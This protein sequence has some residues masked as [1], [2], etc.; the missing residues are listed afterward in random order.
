MVLVVALANDSPTAQLLASTC[1]SGTWQMALDGALLQ[2]RQAALR[3]Y[4]WQR[5]TLS[6]GFHQPLE[7]LSWCDWQARGQ[8]QLV[9][10]PTGGGAVLHGGDLC[11]ALVLPAPRLSRQQAY[12]AICQWL[13]RSFAEL[14]E[15]LRFG[16]DP[17]GRQSDCFASSTPADLIN[18]AGHKRIG[19]AQRWQQGWLLQHG[20]IQLTPDPGSWRQLLGT[21]A[22]PL[23]DL[24]LGP[25]ELMEHLHQTARQWLQLPQQ[26]LPLEAELL[27]AAGQQ[28]ERYRLPGAPSGDTSPL[29]SIERTTWGRA[30]PSG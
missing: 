1:L 5:P 17:A 13:Q 27:A 9:R 11:Y 28:L 24:G 7:P 14:G 4:R 16:A 29:A 8:G 20:S 12:A 2:R 3:L 19:S 30:R 6:L 15:P 23:P 26:P 18:P 10:R 21:E 22:P 25:D